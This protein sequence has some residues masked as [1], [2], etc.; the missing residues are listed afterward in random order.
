MYPLLLK[1]I[2]FGR[3]LAHQTENFVPSILAESRTDHLDNLTGSNG[4]D[5]A[6]LPQ[7]SP[8]HIPDRNPAA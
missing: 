6:A 1:E 7:R 2:L 5:S 3:D 8:S 4:P